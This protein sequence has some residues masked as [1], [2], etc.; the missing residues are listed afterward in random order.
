MERL[1]L[2]LK[3]RSKGEII[4]VARNEAMERSK[5]TFSGWLPPRA[6]VNPFPEHCPRMKRKVDHT[7]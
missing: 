7:P 2:K 4:F 1:D 6:L 3:T 5:V